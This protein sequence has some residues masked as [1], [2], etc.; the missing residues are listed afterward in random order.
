MLRNAMPAG[1]LQQHRRDREYFIA[2]RCNILLVATS[3]DILLNWK[4]QN[5]KIRQVGVLQLCFPE[6]SQKVDNVFGPLLTI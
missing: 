3:S 1:T 5:S 6:T 2:R 4:S